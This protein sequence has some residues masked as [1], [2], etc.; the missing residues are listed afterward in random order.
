[1]SAKDIYIVYKTT[2]LV[3]GKFYIGVHKVSGRGYLGSGLALKGAIKKY[4]RE[5][6]MRDI[7]FSFDNS[8]AAYLKEADV[9]NVEMINNPNCY[10]IGLGGLCGPVMIGKTH[11]MYGKKHSKETRKK[12]SESHKGKYT[13]EN[14]PNYGKTISEEHKKKLREAHTGRKLSKEHKKKMS[15]ARKG[16]NHPMY[17]KKLSQEHKKN[18]S[19]SHKGKILSDEHKKNLSGFT[20]F[21]EGKEYISAVDAGRKLNVSDVTILRWCRLS[22]RPN[23]YR[24]PYNKDTTKTESR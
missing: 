17:G 20:Y 18:L 8:D 2:N 10:N 23:C 21:I 6:F 15:E 24:E 16:E 12:M 14:H 22:S 1:M 3:N 4:G 5:N 9:V 19:E 11:P 7:L 13:G